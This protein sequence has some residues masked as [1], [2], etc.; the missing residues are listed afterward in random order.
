[1]EDSQKPISELEQ[2]TQEESEKIP[3][4]KRLTL[5]EYGAI[6]ASLGIAYSI[7][8]EEILNGINWAYDKIIY[9]GESIGQFFN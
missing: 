3:T 7:F 4:S 8:Q 5:P 1:M 6:I 2:T 9:L